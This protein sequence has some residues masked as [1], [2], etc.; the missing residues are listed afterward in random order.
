M[1]RYVLRRASFV[2]TAV[3]GVSALWAVVAS[4]GP[5]DTHDRAFQ[6]ISH[7]VFAD[8]RLWMLQDDGSLFALQPSDAKPKR[9]A[10]EGKVIEICRSAGHLLA[11]FAANEGQWTI[12]RRSQEEWGG[13]VSFSIEKDSFAA[14]GCAADRPAVA[15]V[16][17]RRLIEIDGAQVRAVKLAPELEPPFT[18]GTAFMDRDTIWVG[19]NV[20]EWGGGL[21]RI[22]L[23]DGKT[24]IVEHNKSAELCG[25]PLNTQ[26]DPVNAIVASPTNASCI[27]AAIGLVHFMSH[28]RIVEVC[29]K[30]V[31]RLYFKPLDPQPPRGTLED[32]EPSSTIAFFGLARS[33]ATLWAV[34]IDGLYSFEGSAPPRFRP[35]PKFEDR[36]GYRVSFE[37]PGIVLVMTDVNQRRSLSG[38]V[39]IIAVR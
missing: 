6:A 37:M 5:T 22:A 13:K 11:L 27:I 25:G 39:P 2:M 35:L 9:V 16:T 1:K 36:D 29:G 15:I 30:S 38:A 26:C 18:I 8:D 4:V 32:G 12:Q 7:A 3:A 19:F 33:G 34:G 28:G 10:T 14:L 17:N 31:R 20:G 21:R 23:A 24:Q